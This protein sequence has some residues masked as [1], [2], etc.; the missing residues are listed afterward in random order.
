MVHFNLIKIKFRY[1]LTFTNEIKYCVKGIVQSSNDLK[2]KELYLEDALSGIRR[3]SIESSV[4]TTKTHS[5]SND[6]N[7]LVP[8]DLSLMRE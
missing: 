4:K 5:L 1:F 3:D 7:L 8:R 2:K 6:V